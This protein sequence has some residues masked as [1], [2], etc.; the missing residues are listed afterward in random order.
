M[1]EGRG[2]KSLQVLRAH[3]AKNRL[4]IIAA[5]GSEGVPFEMPFLG[6]TL[7]LALGTPTL[8]VLHD[9]RC[10]LFSPSRTT[11]AGSS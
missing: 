3:L 7:K 6:G 10:Y 4:V 9:V 1:S 8:A 5:N 2:S 11:L